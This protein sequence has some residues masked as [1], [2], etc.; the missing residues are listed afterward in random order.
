MDRVVGRV[1]DSA[2]GDVRAFDLD[3]A[4][5]SPVQLADALWDLV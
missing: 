5:L 2:A 3:P 1:T 4:A